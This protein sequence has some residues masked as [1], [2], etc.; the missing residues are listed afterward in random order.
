MLHV[1]Y[2]NELR[3]KKNK[4]N[5]NGWNKNGTKQQTKKQTAKQKNVVFIQYEK[6]Q[7]ELVGQ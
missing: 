3:I 1:I 4:P 7:C 5:R 6:L 2:F